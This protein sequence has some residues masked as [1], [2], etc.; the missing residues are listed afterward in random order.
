MPID[1]SLYHTA[2]AQPVNPLEMLGNYTNVSNALQ[3]NRLLQQQL[4]LLQ[5]HTQ[6]AQIDAQKAQGERVA[7]QYM[8][9][10]AYNTGDG[11]GKDFNKM[12]MDAS[13]NNPFA[14][15]PLMQQR[16]HY[17]QLTQ[18]GIIPP[19]QANAGATISKPLQEVIAQNSTPSQVAPTQQQVPQPQGHQNPINNTQQ[20]PESQNSSSQ[21]PVTSAPQSQPQTPLSQTHTVMTSMPPGYERN[22]AASQ[23]YYQEIQQAA[24]AAKTENAALGN[25]YNLSKAGAPTGQVLGSFYSYL[26]AHNLAPAGAQT[27]AERMQ[28]IK[29]HAAQIA[30]AGGGSRSDQDLFAKQLA[31]VN[32][33]DLPKVLQNMIPYLQG[34]RDMKIA[35]ANYLYKQDS[36]GLDPNKISA[37]RNF[38]QPHSDPRIWELARLQKSD[39]DAFM[40]RIKTLDPAEARELALHSRE[41]KRAGVLGQ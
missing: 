19:G 24:D 35:Q 10:P 20:Q 26:A 39:P 9:D 38:L 22:Q 3:Q 21:A 12:I 25:V 7:A 33:N 1:A 4:P 36:S 5:A 18:S 32:E 8:A 40:S 6:Q 29:D 15:V 17:T 13:P 37:S 11:V 41:L 28:L 16:E 23:Q 31:N 14:V 27:D 30:T 2:P 34:N